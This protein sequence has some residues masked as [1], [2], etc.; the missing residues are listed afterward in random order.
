MEILLKEEDVTGKTEGEN[1]LSVVKGKAGVS[2]ESPINK[3]K[4]IENILT[5][6]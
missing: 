4:H 1:W 2:V 3:S 5:I 6:I